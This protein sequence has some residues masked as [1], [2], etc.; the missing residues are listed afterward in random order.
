MAGI[1]SLKF[2]LSTV[3][4]TIVSGVKVVKALPAIQEEAK[5]LQVEEIVALVVELVTADVPKIVA[6]FKNPA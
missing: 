3:T 2:V 6:A 5:D 4:E 1:D